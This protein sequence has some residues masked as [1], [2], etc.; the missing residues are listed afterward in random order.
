MAQFFTISPLLMPHVSL[1]N[2]K[3]LPSEPG[4]YYAVKGRK[5]L[6]IG[7]AQNLKQ[8]W[9]TTG[10]RKHHQL[11]KLRSIGGV[12]L[13]YRVRRSDIAAKRREARDIKRYLPPLNDRI[14]KPPFSPIDWLLEKLSDLSVA[15]LLG[16]ILYTLSTGIAIGLNPSSIA[17]QYIQRR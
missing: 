16:A 14:E 6:Y 7:K 3:T 4:V 12:R 10:Q 2:L 1:K 5:I 15:V 13:H 11:E 9:C 8:R 17:H